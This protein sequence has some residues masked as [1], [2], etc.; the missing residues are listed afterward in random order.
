MITLRPEKERGRTRL[1]WLDS[2]HSFS[3]GQYQDPH[4]VE[5]RDLRV[6]NDDRVGPGGG[7][8]THPHRDM[9]ILTCVLEGQLAHQDSLGTGSVIGPGELQKMSA[10]SGIRHSEFNASESHPVHFYQIWIYP[11]QSGLAPSYEQKATPP[12]P[13]LHLV[14]SPEGGERAVRVHQDVWV[15]LGRLLDGAEL[16]HALAP[17]RH[18]YLQVTRGQVQLNGLSLSAGDGAAISQEEWL[19]L[20]SP[21]PAEILLFDL[22]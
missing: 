15:Y 1:D 7:F 8:P 13:G 17:D 16:E 21:G 4:H 20:R 12:G 14:A 6:I 3:F 22:N 19:R 10:G 2:R 11:E 18:A 9:E 5:F